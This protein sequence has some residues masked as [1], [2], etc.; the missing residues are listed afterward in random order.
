MES[1][2]VCFLLFFPHFNWSPFFL[3]FLLMVVVRGFF[4]MMTVVGRDYC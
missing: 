1:A 3:L 4:L 2:V